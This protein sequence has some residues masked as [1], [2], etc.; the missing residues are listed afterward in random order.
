MKCERCQELEQ[1]VQAMQ[2]DYGE[3][4]ASAFYRVNRKFA[5]YKS[6]ELER[7]RNELDEHR[8]VCGSAKRREPIRIDGLP[9]FMRQDEFNGTATSGRP[10]AKNGIRQL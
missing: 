10:T 3:A 7:A 1:A 6:V 9:A 8:L 5:A 2:G 4:L